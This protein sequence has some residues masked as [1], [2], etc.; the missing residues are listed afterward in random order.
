M[1]TDRTRAEDDPNGGAGVAQRF[2]VAR[3]F[4]ERSD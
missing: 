4:L 2:V 1:D 3:A